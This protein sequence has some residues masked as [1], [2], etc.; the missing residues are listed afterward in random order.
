MTTLSPRYG[1]DWNP[2]QWDE[3]TIAE[4]IRL[5]QEAG[6]NLVTLG[7][8]S[9]ALTEPEEGRYDFDWLVKLMDRC[10][11]AGIGVDLAT[12][13]ASPPA[14]MARNHPETLPI[15]RNGRTLEFGSRQQFSP[16]NP[17]VRDKAAALAGAL[18][19]AVKGHPALCLWHVGN[20]YGC[21]I[22]ESYDPI[23]IEQFRLW[24]ADHYASIDDLNASWGTTFWSQRYSSFDEVGAPAPLPTFHN[25]AHLRD[26]KH[27]FSDAMIACYE[28]EAQVLREVTPD[29]PITTNFMELFEAIDYWKLAEGVDVV[30]NDSY[31]DPADPYS[32]HRVAFVSDLMRC[33]GGN[34]PS[35]LM[36][37]TTAAV[38]WRNYNALKR[39]GQYRLWSLGHIAHGADAILQFQWRQ[40][41]AGSETFHSAMVDHAGT[42]S[43][44]W[45][46]VCELGAELAGLSE[47]VGKVPTNRIAIVVDWHAQWASRC[48]IARGPL[49]HFADVK[50]WHRTLWEAGFGVDLVPVQASFTA[51]DIVI[52]PSLVALPGDGADVSARLRQAGESGTRVIVSGPTGL[53]D[54]E[55]HA[56]HG[57]YGGPL[58]REAGVF[59]YDTACGVPELSEKWMDEPVRPR[60][61]RITGAIATPARETTAYMSVTHGSPLGE[62]GVGFDEGWAH[63]ETWAD[64]LQVIDDDV[65][66][67]A[68][69][70]RH[71]LM[72]DYADAPAMTHRRLGEGAIVWAGT[73]LGAAARAAVA[74][75]AVGETDLNP[76][77]GEFLPA[78]V[79]CVQRGDVY[80]YLNHSEREV[81]L[82]AA[83][84]DSRYLAGAGT[85]QADTVCLPAR[86]GIALV[87]EPH[88]T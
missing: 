38:Q 1:G 45:D 81:E 48:L 17:Y 70:A 10:A 37:Q 65:E 26:W 40:S 20:E 32:A 23:S 75:W 42:A 43:P 46:E 68:R 60:L 72:S 59:V 41:D 36:E 64:L 78:G 22:A 85:V 87:W 50:A 66:V 16:A 58:A 49:D 24:L 88:E 9:W 57:G 73:R 62:V 3:D 80:F 13:T 77:G 82:E 2:E 19:R 12:G 71:G 79:E 84:R 56:F 52:V 53:T 74:A 25:P 11:E 18:A 31:P 61:D 27:F 83:A 76:T 4:D 5:M 21:H 30:A 51:Y 7:V 28:A 39:P 69:W 55:L 86:S 15:D 6:V 35:I 8:F 67:W 47:V 14:W 54:A 63:G 29:I 44:H 33:L 34:S